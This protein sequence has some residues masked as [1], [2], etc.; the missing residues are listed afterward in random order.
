MNRLKKCLCAILSIVLII[1]ALPVAIVASGEIVTYSTTLSELEEQLY[2]GYKD[3][4]KNIYVHSY[5]ATYNDVSTAIENVFNER[6]DVF[7]VAKT[8]NCSIASDGYVNTITPVY[9]FTAEEVESAKTAINKS[10]NALIGDLDSSMTDIQKLLLLHDRMIL[11]IECVD[12][13]DVDI[14][15][16]VTENDYTIYGAFVSKKGV[17]EAYA[18][19]FKYCVDLLGIENEVVPYST[20]NRCMWNQVK[21]G[22]KW[23][24]VDVRSDDYY[25]SGLFSNVD[26]RCFLFSDTAALDKGYNEGYLTKGATDTTY[27]SNAFWKNSISSVFM[28]GDVFVYTHKRG[29]IC[30]Y[31]F[32]TGASTTLVT[33]NERWKIPN[34]NGGGYPNYFVRAIYYNG[35]IYYN[36][37]KAICT[38]R[39]DGTGKSIIYTYSVDDRQIFGLGYNNGVPSF[40]VRADAYSEDHIIPLT[41]TTKILKAI[42]VT[43]NPTKT[44]YMKGETLDTSGMVVTASYSDGSKFDLIDTDYTVSEF[45]SSSVGSKSLT[46]S[47]GGKTCPLNLSVVDYGDI[48][49][50]Y[51]CT[52]SDLLKLQQHF[53]EISILSDSEVTLAD[54]DKNGILDSVD[55]LTLQTKILGVF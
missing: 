28:A 55:I 9:L 32:T 38:I 17:C 54:I 25:S 29:M 19:A 46:I 44:V 34:T 42:N 48:D 52:S 2:L 15:D 12:E 4:A 7:Y 18:K 35:Y 43:T 37:P 49:M 36:M 51:S 45:D 21:T 23:Y 26:H 3:M 27:D 20:T 1:T 6:P 40:T 5:S 53:F 8:I 24:N 31:D 41:Q 11:D 47:Y 13:D 16:T 10:V 33:L 30:T 50:D 22:G 39:P 14:Y